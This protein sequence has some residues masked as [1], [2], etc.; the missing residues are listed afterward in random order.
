MNVPKMLEDRV[1]LFLSAN[2]VLFSP[3]IGDTG[4]IPPTYFE[5]VVD[6]R[7]NKMLRPE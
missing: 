2:N 1:P 5:K 7:T 3:G 6:R 4:F